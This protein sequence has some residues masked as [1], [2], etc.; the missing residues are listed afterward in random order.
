M[1]LTRR[2]AGPRRGEEQHREGD[3]VRLPDPAQRNPAEVPDLFGC[4]GQRKLGGNA[5]SRYDYWEGPPASDDP[6]QWLAGATEHHGSWWPQ[7][8]EWLIE[9]SGPEKKP[10]SALGNR[11]YPP[12]G[13]APGT[14]VH[15]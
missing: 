14:Y 3:L 15:Q 13:P 10:G 6:D 11:K 12:L 2:P 4:L 8:I 5:K 7:W 9:H 1:H